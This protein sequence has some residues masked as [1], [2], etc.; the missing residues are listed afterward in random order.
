MDFLIHNLSNRNLKQ[1]CPCACKVNSNELQLLHP[2]FLNQNYQ[3]NH[4]HLEP[5]LQSHYHR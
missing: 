5:S 1:G 4:T 3:A 2:T